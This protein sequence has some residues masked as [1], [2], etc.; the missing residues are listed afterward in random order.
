MR[1]QC[2]INN[3]QK[4][5]LKHLKFVRS[6]LISISTQNNNVKVYLLNLMPCHLSLAKTE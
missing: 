1:T 3:N 2:L 4:Y 5:R 6:V